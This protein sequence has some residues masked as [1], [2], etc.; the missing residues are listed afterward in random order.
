MRQAIE[1][2]QRRKK[3]ETA[4]RAVPLLKSRIQISYSPSAA[5]PVVAGCGA[6][7]GQSVKLPLSDNIRYAFPLRILRIYF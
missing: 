3:S 6:G 1:A 5:S 2:R 4:V 7:R